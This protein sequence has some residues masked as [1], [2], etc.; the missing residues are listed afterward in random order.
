MV[1]HS[2]STRTFVAIALAAVLIPCAVAYHQAIIEYL[3]REGTQMSD[4]RHL[5]V[6]AQTSALKYL[7]GSRDAKPDDR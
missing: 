3:G 5:Q 7:L 6:E 1:G 4:L 2:H